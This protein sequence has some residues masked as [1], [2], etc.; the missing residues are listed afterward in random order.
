MDVCTKLT[1]FAEYF[2]E[3]LIDREYLNWS[4]MFHELLI[5]NFTSVGL[6]KMLRFEMKVLNEIFFK[7][8]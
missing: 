5:V 1:R 7:Q 6:F 4:A 2:E 8:I 3:I